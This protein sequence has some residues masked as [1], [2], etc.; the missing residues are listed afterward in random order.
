MQVVQSNLFFVSDSQMEVQSADLLRREKVRRTRRKRQQTAWCLF[1]ISECT[2]LR[3]NDPIVSKNFSI[4]VDSIVS[5]VLSRLNG[6][7]DGL[8]RTGT[9][10][11]STVPVVPRHYYTNRFVNSA[12]YTSKRFLAPLG[13]KKAEMLSQTPGLYHVFHRLRGYR[14]TWPVAAATC[15]SGKTTINSFLCHL[16]ASH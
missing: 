12:R 9:V 16:A 6:R 7:D 8:L 11:T 15:C 10:G 13:K 1:Y 3:L 5:R 2:V 4:T 14:S